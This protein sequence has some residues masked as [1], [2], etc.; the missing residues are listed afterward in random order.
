MPLSSRFDLTD[1]PDMVSLTDGW[2][3]LFFRHAG[4]LLARTVQRR[5]ALDARPKLRGAG[6]LEC[7]PRRHAAGKFTKTGLETSL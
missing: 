6:R 7:G 5:G 1:L 4:V 2:Q 3:I